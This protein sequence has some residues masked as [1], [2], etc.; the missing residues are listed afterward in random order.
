MAPGQGGAISLRKMALIDQGI[1]Q[2]H[3]RCGY[4]RHLRSLGNE[5]SLINPGINRPPAQ[6]RR[7]GWVSFFI[8]KHE[9]CK[10]VVGVI[11]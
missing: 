1:N 8:G 7:H 11:L 2:P 10:H 5:Q 3:Q 6:V 9:H 4:S